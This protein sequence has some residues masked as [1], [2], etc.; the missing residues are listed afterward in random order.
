MQQRLIDLLDSIIS[1]LFWVPR[2]DFRFRLSLKTF[3]LLKN[4]RT[5]VRLFISGDNF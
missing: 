2:G 3:F 5:T 1:I 4:Y